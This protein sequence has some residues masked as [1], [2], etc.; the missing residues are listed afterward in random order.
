M[1]LGAARASLAGSAVGM[2]K[3]SRA[4]KVDRHFIKPERRKNPVDIVACLALFSLPPGCV[5]I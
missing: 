4:D 5:H 2:G 3:Q 1:V